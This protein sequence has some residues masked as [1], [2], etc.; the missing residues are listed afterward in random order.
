MLM[1]AAAASYLPLPV[2]A[3]EVSAQADT[4]L[5]DALR[6]GHSR[7]Q[8]TVPAELAVPALVSSQL[9]VLER[10][11]LRTRLF[12]PGVSSAGRWAAWHAQQTR[13]PAQ[14]GP[15]CEVLGMGTLDDKDT[16]LLLVGP[17]NRAGLHAEPE[18][19]TIAHVQA[20]LSRSQHRTV[21]MLN[22]DLEALVVSARLVR[23]IRPMFMADFEHA[24]FLATVKSRLRGDFGDECDAEYSDCVAVRRLFPHDWE[25]FC[26]DAIG[27]EVAAVGEVSTAGMNTP[28]GF[29]GSG[30]GTGSL[31]GGG[32]SLRSLS[33]AIRA[34]I[35]PI[36]QR[37]SKTKPRE[38]DALS[39]RG[40][41][42]SI[43]VAPDYQSDPPV[44]RRVMDLS[45]SGVEIELSGREPH[46]SPEW[47]DRT[48]Y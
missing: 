16:A 24:F 4:A 2:G 27:C 20:L 37:I 1:S 43:P 31:C 18:G 3:G 14:P 22:P 48:H 17:C 39:A 10:A 33:A 41:S 8:V 28:V 47:S 38:A 15:R 9:A 40:S 26:T 34:P 12:F 13:S 42:V 30:L 21:V 5:A 36:R 29:R 32:V 46:P 7:V 25:L 44:V 45:G 6:S 19:E 35:S 23:P 11:G